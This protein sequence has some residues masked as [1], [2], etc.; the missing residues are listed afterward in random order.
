MQITRLFFRVNGLKQE[1]TIH[2][3]Y[4]PSAAIET[5]LTSQCPCELFCKTAIELDKVDNVYMW[6]ETPGWDTE[7]HTQSWLFSSSWSVESPL[8]IMIEYT[9][10]TVVN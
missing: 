10:Q 5:I 4:V 1:T 6:D 2:V 8:K 9:L 7:W 3:T